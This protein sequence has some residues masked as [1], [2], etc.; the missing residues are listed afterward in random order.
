MS[1]KSDAG[2][3]FI[4]TASLFIDN[5]YSYNYCTLQI[6]NGSLYWPL[7]LD[8]SQ[9]DNTSSWLSDPPSQIAPQTWVTFEAS[10]SWGSGCNASVTYRA[11]TELGQQYVSMGVEDPVAIEDNSVT[12]NY[13]GPCNCTSRIVDKSGNQATGV[14]YV[15]LGESPP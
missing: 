5:L 4:G 11:T 15:A 2:P 13:S 9:V 7:S 12:M 14:F 3:K 8:D 6:Y 10:S 1:I